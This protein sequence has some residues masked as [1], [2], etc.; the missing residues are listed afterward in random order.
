MRM[1]LWI[2]GDYLDAIKAAKI[3]KIVLHNPAQ[4]SSKETVG[5]TGHFNHKKVAAWY[6]EVAK[7]R[8]GI[9]YPIGTLLFYQVDLKAE[10]Q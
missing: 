4:L 2:K 6:C 1:K 9:G 7:C 8:E 10:D 5:E 3:R